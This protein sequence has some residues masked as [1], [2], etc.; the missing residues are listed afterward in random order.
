MIDDSCYVLDVFFSD[1]AEFIIRFNIKSVYR[2]VE[3]KDTINSFLA[4]RFILDHVN[5]KRN[6]LSRKKY[7]RADSQ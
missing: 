2:N 3:I 1:V 4:P 6:G 7:E 5:G